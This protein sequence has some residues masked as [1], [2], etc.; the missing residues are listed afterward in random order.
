M[1]KLQEVKIEDYEFKVEEF[2]LNGCE[3][4]NVGIAHDSSTLNKHREKFDK[5]IRDTD[6]LV[7]E[8]FSHEPSGVI[9]DNPGIDTL[10][11]FDST[12]EVRDFYNGI[13]K[14]CETYDKQVV[15]VDPHISKFSPASKAF[16]AIV[17]GLGTGMFLG[18]LYNSAKQKRISRRKFL[19][20]GILFSAG[21]YFNYNALPGHL[22]RTLINGDEAVL[23]EIVTYGLDDILI[24]DAI[25]YR[26]MQAGINLS[27]FTKSIS[28]TTL[29]R[30]KITVISGRGHMEP[31]KQ[32]A[33]NPES[34]ELRIKSFPRS[35]YNLVGEPNIRGYYFDPV[36]KVW[37][38]NLNF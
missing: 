35:V 19:R 20:T 24:V 29:K 26:N 11:L 7:P 2:E 1:E 5:L 37:I 17:L 25:N 13:S 16:E 23:K 8:Y 34:T 3:I 31:V 30:S 9:S 12:K 18:E 14:L 6:F 33:S 28:K 21:F 22:L 27:R 32:Y 10:T 4:K 15:V 36:T 38:Q